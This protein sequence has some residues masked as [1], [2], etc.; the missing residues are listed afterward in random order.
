MRLTIRPRKWSGFVAALVALVVAGCGVAKQD[1]ETRRSV[2]SLGAWTR[3][4]PM[5]LRTLEHV[6]VSPET[7]EA[8]DLALRQALSERGL[9]AIAGA[10]RDVVELY[11]VV[12]SFRSEGGVDE[13]FLS[14]AGSAKI[15]VEMSLRTPSGEKLGTMTAV[16][17]S[18]VSGVLPKLATPGLLRGSADALAEQLDAAVHP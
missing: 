15:T 9:L 5:P 16:E 13:K 18:E 3:F 11:P 1:V 7:R 2:K 8:F 4:E 6:E 12:V 10:A 14:T 17:R